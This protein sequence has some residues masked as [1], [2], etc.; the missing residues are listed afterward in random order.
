M[1]FFLH[2]YI[3]WIFAILSYLGL[4]F[5]RARI[6]KVTSINQDSLKNVW[7]RPL[8]HTSYLP[9][10]AASHATFLKR[11]LPRGTFFFSWSPKGSF[12]PFGTPKEKKLLMGGR[13]GF[14]FFWQFFS[15]CEKITQ[16]LEFCKYQG[17]KI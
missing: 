12:F 9:N 16:F 15:T 11:S 8:V 5:T 2:F 7:H 1:N 17:G 6:T 13:P 3:S 14:L 10:A 4:K